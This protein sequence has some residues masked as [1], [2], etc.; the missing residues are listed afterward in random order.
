[1][2]KY[3]DRVMEEV[4]FNFERHYTEKDEQIEFL[5]DLIEVLNNEL[6]EREECENG[7]DC[8]C[9]DGDDQVLV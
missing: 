8:E 3:V 2:S 1:M 6:N 5:V 9:C 4:H 7:E